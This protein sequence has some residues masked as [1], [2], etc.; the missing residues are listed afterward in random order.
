[1]PARDP[2]RPA[3]REPAPA[4]EP[5]VQLCTFRIGGEDYAVDIMRIREIIHPLPITPVPRAPASVEGVVRLRGEVIPVLDVRKRL[6]LPASAPTRR[7]RFLVVNVARRRIGL[8]VDQV[9]EVI[10]IPRSELRPAPPLGDDRAPRFFLGVCGGEGVSA[11]GRRAGP[12]RLRLLLNVK[13]LLDP[14]VPGEADAA[15]AQADASRAAPDAAART[16]GGGRA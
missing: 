1:M 4:D 13:A 6:G 10:R 16:P 5:L 8:V 11:R 9:S 14:A 2:A 15:R 12:G 7:T 3:G